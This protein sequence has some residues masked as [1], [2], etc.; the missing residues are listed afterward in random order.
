MSRI[1]YEIWWFPTDMDFGPVVYNVTILM[2]PG[3][4]GSISQMVEEPL[5]KYVS[6]SHNKLICITFLH[7]PQLISH[8]KMIGS[9]EC[10]H[11]WV[12]GMATWLGHWNG[13]MI[14]SLESKLE[15]WSKG[16][17]KI[18]F[19]GHQLLWNEALASHQYGIYL[20]N[21]VYNYKTHILINISCHRYIPL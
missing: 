20:H 15:Q 3:L 7:M 19:G 2:L 18:W 16:D 5:F 10:Q 8:D 9:L 12:I 1:W 6:L 13:D 17:Y 11:D 21:C 4:M 14:G